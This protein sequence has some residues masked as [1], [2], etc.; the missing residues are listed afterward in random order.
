MRYLAVSWFLIAL[1]TGAAEASKST[2][3]KG[4]QL[5][6]AGQTAEAVTIFLK[7]SQEGDPLAQVNLAVLQA[8]GR[9]VPQDDVSAAYW[10]W[11]ARF[12]GEDQAI[13][14][15]EYLLA[16]LTEPA[17]K[18]LAERL[19]QD[20]QV[21]AADG[22]VTAFLSLG[23]VALELRSPAQEAKALEWLSLAAAFEVP[24]A[25][26]LRD[27]VALRLEQSTRLSV[28]EKTIH[29]FAKWCATLPNHI[30]IPTCPSR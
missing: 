20:L 6:E 12:A 18:R 14:L 27:A 10:A 28:Q 2:F 7:L 15:A 26:L 8:L 23:R 5:A 30:R 9:G 29:A 17:Q 24:K 4:M 21:L 1:A 13:T 3:A 25:T 22:D 11:R 19:E 16:R